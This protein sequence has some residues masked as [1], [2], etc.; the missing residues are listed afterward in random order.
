[1]LEGNTRRLL[2]GQAK[3]IAMLERMIAPREPYEVSAML[4][5]LRSEEEPDRVTMHVA[6]EDEVSEISH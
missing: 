3:M 1:V 6:S 5:Q 4:R 2:E